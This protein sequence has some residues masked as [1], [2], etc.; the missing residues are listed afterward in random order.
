MTLKY[1]SLQEF[2]KKKQENENDLK[3]KKVKLYHTVRHCDSDEIL[4]LLSYL[5]NTH[6]FFFSIED[7]DYL[8]EYLI[9]AKEVDE[10][11]IRQL[12]AMNHK[13][14]NKTLSA[15]LDLQINNK[16]S[17]DLCEVFTI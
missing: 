5:V 11:I 14:S 7:S 16:I 3:N 12:L 8:Y 6:H 4:S 10:V 13:I 9:N 2:I 1:I 15:V 17:S